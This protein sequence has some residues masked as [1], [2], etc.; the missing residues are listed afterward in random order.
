[1]VR[2]VAVRPVVAVLL[3]GLVFGL[4]ES[5]AA[6]TAQQKA[7]AQRVSDAMGV[8]GRLFAEGKY[9]EC[10][11]AIGTLQK[12]IERITAGGNAEL[13]DQLE[14]VIRRIR[15]AQAFLAIQGFELPPLKI[16]EPK[17]TTPANPPTP[18]PNVPATVEKVSFSKH[19]AP[20]LVKKCGRCHVDKTSGM[21][22]MV[23]FD[24]LMKGPP[25]G[26]VIFKGDSVGSR[27]VE[28][29]Q[30]NEMPPNGTKVT[31]DELATVKKWIDQGAVFD[32][33]DTNSN[34]ASVAGVSTGAVAP[35]AV[36]KATGNESVSFAR[37]I[38]PVLTE[39]CRG[40]HIGATRPS[41]RFDMATFSLLLKGGESGPA[42]M[43]GKPADSILVQKIKGTGG[44]QRMPAGGRPPLSDEVIAKISTWIAEGARFDGTDPAQSIVSVAALARAKSA[45]HE[46]LA[47]DRA[48]RATEHWQLGMAGIEAQ[49]VTTKN[50]LLIG[51]Q[52]EAT[53]ASFGPK[54]EA[55]VPRVAGMFGAP[56][57]QPLV[58]GRITLYLFQQRYD[59]GEFGTMVEKRQLPEAWRGHW[60]FDYVDAYAAM[61]PSK[62]DD[63]GFEPLVAQQVAAA[64][65]ASLGSVPRWF[66]EGSGRVVASRIDPKDKRVTG[67]TEQM[68]EVKERMAKADDFLEGRLAPEDADIA[69][70]SF[71]DFLMG[72]ANATKYANVVNA[73]R[74]GD[75]FQ[76]AF[77]AQFNGS[78]GQQ[79]EIWF[80]TAGKST[81][82]TK[83][84]AKK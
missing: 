47:A 57:D 53:L 83:R 6:L 60:K 16:G 77:S 20:I 22:S 1:M 4:A 17:A 78:P 26:V 5:P 27:L 13:N 81:G 75:D 14:P 34:L 55:V 58:K 66:A 72:K 50:F 49:N 37:D 61:I 80:K 41:G 45:T 7:D 33:S 42:I 74:K 30:G 29:I 63:Y 3:L 82:P 10:A 48:K 54:A 84:P 73:L 18:A 8:A 32:G 65:L 79:A 59:Y 68:A 64:Y 62:T 69:A 43:P 36:Q 11:D 76:K 46:E 40:C 70:F 24:A 15:N 38:A 9:K 21:F 52:G 12:D 35:V 28:V 51:N 67:W 25:A 44:G 19:V 2:P 56:S 71:A 39:A 31:P 23:T